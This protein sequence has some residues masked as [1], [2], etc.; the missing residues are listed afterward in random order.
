MQEEINDLYAKLDVLQWGGS[1]APADRT[2]AIRKESPEFGVKEDKG[3]WYFPEDLNPSFWGISW[4]PRVGGIPGQR[5][6]GRG[7]GW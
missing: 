6:Q 3:A 2:A 4:R 7:L 1:H 5:P